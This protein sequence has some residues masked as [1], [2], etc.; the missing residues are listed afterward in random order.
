MFHGP[1]ILCRL[2]RLSPAF[3]NCLK[4]QLR[5][6]YHL[7]YGAVARETYQHRTS[8]FVLRKTFFSF[9][10][11]METDGSMY[12]HC[13]YSLTLC[14]ISRVCTAETSRYLFLRFELFVVDLCFQVKRVMYRI[15]LTCLKNCDLASFINV[16]DLERQSVFVEFIL[17]ICATQVLSRLATDD[18]GDMILPNFLKC[19]L[20][21]PFVSTMCSAT[22]TTACSFTLQAPY[23]TL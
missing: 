20:C 7:I 12:T 18:T 4:L 23:H 15:C 9:S 13:G 22:K 16:C 21:S 3:C 19:R 8:E 6:Y 14:T 2:A 10:L 17:Y 1:K 5:N 11:S